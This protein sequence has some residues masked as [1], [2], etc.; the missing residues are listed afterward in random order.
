MDSNY[1]R[2]NDLLAWSNALRYDQNL[3]ETDR[4]ARWRQRLE[5]EQLDDMERRTRWGRMSYT[6]R[7]SLGLAGGYVRFAYSLQCIKLIYDVSGTPA[8]ACRAIT[9]P[10]LSDQ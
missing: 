9:I 7:S 4:V 3:K 1:A 2:Y 5:F 10:V 8:W 6:D